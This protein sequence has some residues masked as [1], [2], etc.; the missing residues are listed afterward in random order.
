MGT[1]RQRLL[2]ELENVQVPAQSPSVASW[3]LSLDIPCLLARPGAIGRQFSSSPRLWP[4]GRSDSCAGFLMA[5]CRQTLDSVCK[6]RGVNARGQKGKHEQCKAAAPARRPSWVACDLL[7]FGSTC[8]GGQHPAP[9]MGMV[10]WTW[11]EAS[12]GISSQSGLSTLS[13]TGFH[14][15]PP[16]HQQCLTACVALWVQHSKGQA[17]GCF[18]QPGHLVCIIH[19]GASNQNGS[20]TKE[21]TTPRGCPVCLEE[22]IEC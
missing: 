22:A 5:S 12:P 6:S 13:S 3:Q 21:V 19:P 10:A 18:R 14:T 20:R 17:P 15:Q 9:L 11:S 1:R 7:R 16:S 4:V 2:L 8:R